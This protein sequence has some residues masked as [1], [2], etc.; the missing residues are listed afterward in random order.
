MPYCFIGWQPQR[1]LMLQNRTAVV[2]AMLT[3]GVAV[4][5]ILMLEKNGS[6]ITQLWMGIA[7]H[8]LGN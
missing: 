8:K 2:Y 1:I 6:P 4:Q 7:Q 5:S 3:Y